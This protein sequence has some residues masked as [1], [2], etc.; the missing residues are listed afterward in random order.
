V[1]RWQ[2]GRDVLLIELLRDAVVA[3]WYATEKDNGTVSYVLL[4][5]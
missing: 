4:G 2:N 3:A 1:L 5:M